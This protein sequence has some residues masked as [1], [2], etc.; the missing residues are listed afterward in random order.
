L[1]LLAIADK[2]IW[3]GWGMV[4]DM[5]EPDE[6]KIKAGMGKIIARTNAAIRQ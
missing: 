5:R 2:S 4:Q 6:Y 1:V 3:K